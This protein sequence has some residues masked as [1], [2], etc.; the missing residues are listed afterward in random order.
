MYERLKKKEGKKIM[1]GFVTKCMANGE[2]LI[3][4]LY[5]SPNSVYFFVQKSDIKIR[6][7]LKL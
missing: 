4:F 5:I 6:V 7:L 3:A 1:K 2:K